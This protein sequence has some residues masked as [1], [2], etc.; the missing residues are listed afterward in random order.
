METEE[1]T[2]EET[3][4]SSNH[5]V[6]KLVLGTAAGLAMTKLVEFGI[7]CWFN[8]RNKSDSTTIE[9]TVPETE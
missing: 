6:L 1:T 2:V 3:Q 8:R 7:D 5:P 4:E 9:E